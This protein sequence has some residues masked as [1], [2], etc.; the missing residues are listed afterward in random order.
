MVG[1]GALVLALGLQMIL[2]YREAT[3][4]TDGLAIRH[5]R[6]I[7]VPTLPESP[8]ILHAP[9]FAPDRRPG[10]AGGS[11][12]AGMGSLG[13]YAALGAASGHGVASAVVSGPAGAVKTLRPGDEIDGWRLSVV[14]A[15][16]LTFE[17]KGE[18]HVLVV[19]EPAEAVAKASGAAPDAASPADPQ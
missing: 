9:I 3:P 12:S 4:A 19:G 8:A 15:S 2:P 14:S 16:R 13:Q 10:E 5:P 7:V 1:C 17:R 18:R 11:A 6:L